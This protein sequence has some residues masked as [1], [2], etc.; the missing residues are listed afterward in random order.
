MIWRESIVHAAM[1]SARAH[2]DHHSA[3]TRLAKHASIPN[4]SM[5]GR[6]PH[7]CLPRLN[8]KK[9]NSYIAFHRHQDSETTGPL[10]LKTKNYHNTHPLCAKLCNDTKTQRQLDPIC[11]YILC[12]RPP[13][14][15]PPSSNLSDKMDQRQCCGICVQQPDCPHRHT[16]C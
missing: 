15:S 14:H 9:Y 6:R 11:R 16:T 7:T 5:Q 10:H 13:T 4:N 1:T 2:I 12:H 3:R 8:F